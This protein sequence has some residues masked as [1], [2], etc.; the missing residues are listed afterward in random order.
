MADL[1][2]RYDFHTHT[3]FSDGVLLP[4]ALVYEAAHRGHA[5]IALTDHVDASNLE[6]TIA[7]L[8]RFVK[9]Q[10]PSLPLK[11]IAGVELSYLAPSLIK[12]Y[13]RRAR[14]LGAE[15]VV[16]HG[17]SP[18]EPVPKGTN[19]A[20]LQCKGLVDILAH[21]GWINEEEAI[22][23]KVN[24]I[25]LELS[26]RKG[27]RKGNRHVAGLAKQFGAKLLVDTDSH[28]EKD[29]ITQKEA[30]ELVRDLGFKQEAALKIIKDNPE[31]LLRRISHR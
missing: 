11:V 25:Y 3:V 22:L 20:A 6:Q 5:A 13:A 4:A 9:E 30:Y 8:T 31:D 10:G 14:E 18:V 27:H 12:P 29:L 15:I 1:G 23:A 26:A 17:E 19:R 2:P 7:T 24:D 28:S 16:V 21:P